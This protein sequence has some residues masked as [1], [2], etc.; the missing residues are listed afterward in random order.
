MADQ[1][2]ES[3]AL[4]LLLA[5]VRMEAGAFGER[6]EA[7]PDVED[8]RLVVLDVLVRA[9]SA[10]LRGESRVLVDRDAGGAADDVVRD[11]VAGRPRP[12]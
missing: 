9:D 8:L 2:R 3:C 10:P 6:A 1:N 12:A 11:L 7:I 5:R 4:S